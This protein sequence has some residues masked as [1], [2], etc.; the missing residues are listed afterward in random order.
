MTSEIMNEYNNKIGKILD[1]IPYIK[2]F[3]GVIIVSIIETI[4]RTQKIT[5]KQ[6]KAIN[7]IYTK[8]NIKNLYIHKFGT[9]RTEQEQPPSYEPPSYEP[10]PYSV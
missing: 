1:V 2:G 10:P 9:Y 3:N 7:N 6:A 4:K 5:Y 8:W